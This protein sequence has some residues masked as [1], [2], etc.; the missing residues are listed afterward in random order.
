MAKKSKIR[1]L[2]KKTLAPTPE[3]IKLLTEALSFLDQ[4]IAIQPPRDLSEPDLYELYMI[5]LRFG[6][7]LVRTALVRLS[8]IETIL[9]EREAQREP[10]QEEQSA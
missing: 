4:V 2:P 10:V 1:A 7:S 8:R 3:E 9:A 5:P 6:Q